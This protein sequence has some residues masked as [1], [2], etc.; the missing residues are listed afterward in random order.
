MSKK[1]NNKLILGVSLLIETFIFLAVFATIVIK[2]RSIIR[3][4][5]TVALLG[6]AAG[7]LLTIQA[8]KKKNNYKSMRQAVDDLC[9]KPVKKVKEDIDIVV[10]DTA[11]ESDFE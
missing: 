5:I 1:N 3:T 2:R 6:G 4:V 10:D 7:T 11:T 8:I 9:E